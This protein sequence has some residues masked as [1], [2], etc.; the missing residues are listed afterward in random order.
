MD[1]LIVF[2]SRLEGVIPTAMY[3][4][5]GQR[6]DLTDEGLILT[7]DASVCSQIH[8]RVAFSTLQLLAAVSMLRV[9]AGNAHYVR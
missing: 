6:T 5:G 7:L 9:S 3:R 1:C 8:A 2:I 4:C